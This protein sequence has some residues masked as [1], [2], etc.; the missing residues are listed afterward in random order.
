M[1]FL[2]SIDLLRCLRGPRGDAKKRLRWGGCLKIHVNAL[3]RHRMRTLQV[4]G[5]FSY[6]TVE[7]AKNKSAQTSVPNI[8]KNPFFCVRKLRFGA[9]FDDCEPPHKRKTFTR[10]KIQKKR[11]MMWYCKSGLEVGHECAI[12]SIRT[13]L[14][15]KNKSWY[16][17]SAINETAAHVAVEVQSPF[18]DALLHA[19]CVG[20]YLRS[21]FTSW[22]PNAASTIPLKAMLDWKRV[23][24]DALCI[25][26]IGLDRSFQH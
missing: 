11:I 10:T 16:Q 19:A 18:V 20:R 21:K 13:S 3:C 8:I 9:C 15:K 22:D 6:Y 25:E 14:C 12:M 17:I 24:N 2:W 23:A 5:A 7:F 1:F 4:H 26:S